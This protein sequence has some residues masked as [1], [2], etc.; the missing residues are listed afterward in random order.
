[1]VVSKRTRHR[2]PSGSTVKTVRTG[3]PLST[4]IRPGSGSLTS[5]VIDRLWP[6][7]FIAKV[8]TVPAP[9]PPR[10]TRKA[11]K[12]GGKNPSGR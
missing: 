3:S 7:I 10:S 5:A 9:M 6:P 4:S 2:R 11:V 12:T 1:M 8:M